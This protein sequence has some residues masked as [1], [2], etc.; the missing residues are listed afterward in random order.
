MGF[1]WGGVG[2]GIGGEHVVLVPGFEGVDDGVGDEAA[3]GA[4]AVELHL[5]FGGVDVD[6]DLG[7]V[8]FEEEAAEGVAALH[9]GVVVAFEEGGVEASVFDGAAVDEEMLVIAGA[10]GDAWGADPAPEAGF[11]GWGGVRGCVDVGGGD[12]GGFEATAGVDGDEGEAVPEEE[13]E[14]LVEGVELGGWGVGVG[15]WGELPD[16]AA[17]EGEGEADVGVGEGGGGEPV[18]DVGAF[19]VVAA[20]EFAAGGDVEEEVADF[21]GG[22]VG[23]A[24]LPDLED[25]TAVDDDLGGGGGV[26]CAAFAGGE[27]EAGDAGDAWDGLAAEAEGGDAGEVGGV[28]D[29][30]G[31]VAFEAEE[32]VVAAHAGA[33]VG[34]AE[35]G[36][37]CGEGFDGDAGGAGVDAVFDQFLDDA[38]R[39]F[40]DLAGGDLV[41]H[42]F[43]EESDPV[44]GG[45]DQGARWRR[46]RTSLARTS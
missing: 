40:D 26:G 10:A 39:A 34:D 6:V 13:A 32:G 42:V 30:A 11:C 44:H 25:A 24:G 41:R 16:C 37:A 3:D 23:G 21:E 28:G 14:A 19:G 36:A 1:G 12:S 4:F 22:A 20:E 43:G 31:G 27:G 7:G 18:L 38:G 35:E 46:L 45:G 15:E 2:W 33:V 9:E 8:E 29:F 5:A 17:F